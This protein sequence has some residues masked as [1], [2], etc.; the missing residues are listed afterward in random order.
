MKE[1][2][3]QYVLQYLFGIYCAAIIIQ[4]TLAAKNITILGFTLTTGVLI[5]PILF[6]TQD[7]TTEIFKFKQA[8]KMIFLSFVMNLAAVVL[9]QLA[10]II[11]PSPLYFN[12]NSFSSILGTS[13]RIAVASFV[14]YICGS[15]ANSK[16]MAL[17]KSKNS[18]SFFARAI[19]STIVG[20]LIDNAVFSIVA[21]TSVL[22]IQAIA[23]MIIGATIFET[24]Y[25][26]ILFPITKASVQIINKYC[27]K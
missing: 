16:I 24:V 27:S 7:I 5:S 22:P 15:L 18:R 20:Q 14:A 8:K 19:S 10:I 3:K 12:Q 21:F 9:Y 26:I 1:F 2:K 25:E 13:V 6:I 4:N 17:M 23:S 11:P